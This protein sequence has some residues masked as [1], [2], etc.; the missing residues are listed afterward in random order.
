[1]NWFYDI[2]IR[3]LNTDTP[4]P[5]CT[6]HSSSFYPPHTPRSILSYPLIFFSVLQMT[7]LRRFH[8]K[9]AVLHAFPVS[10]ILFT[11][12]VDRSLLDFA[13]VTIIGADP[14]DRVV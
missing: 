3:S 12:A 6:A 8:T 2:I 7:T 9:I 1:M 14:S 5:F 4:I 10:L 11:F 13:L